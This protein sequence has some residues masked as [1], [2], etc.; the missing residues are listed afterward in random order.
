LEELKSTREFND[1]A[2]KV[3]TP[4]YD[5]LLAE[6]PKGY[7]ETELPQFR[8]YVFPTRVAEMLND[9]H[10]KAAVDGVAV[11]YGKINQVMRNAIFFNPLIHIP[12]IGNH[13]LVDRGVTPWQ[14][15][16]DYSTLGATSVKAWKA[17]T[18]MNEDYVAALDAGAHLLFAKTKME[19]MAQ[20]FLEKA[21]VELAADKTL[22][23]HIGAELGVLN[24]VTWVKSV[25]KFSSKATWA[26]NDIATLQRVYERMESGGL[27][28]E[29]A[30]EET[31]KHI[32]NYRIP[33]RVLNSRTI[34]SILKGDSG[35]TMFGAYHYGALK[36]YGEMIGNLVD[37]M[38]GKAA[39]GVVAETLDKIAALAVATYVIYPMLDKAAQTVTGNPNAS[40]RRAGAST[41]LANAQKLIE[42]ATADSEYTKTGKLK[43]GV[44]SVDIARF[45]QSIVTPSVGLKVGMEFYFGR[46]TF[47]GRP[48]SYGQKAM[49]ALS[50]IDYARQMYDGSMGFGQ[51]VA[52]LIGVKLPE[53][54]GGKHRKI[55]LGGYPE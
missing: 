25:Y 21:G 12:N 22:A 33:A 11:A 10:R 31:A 18:T 35:L 34:A 14:K 43:N 54:K 7:R 45:V 26:A 2:V 48:I 36:S 9:F 42:K 23:G 27:S 47:N 28:L 4:E 20:M 44:T 39:P 49:G 15:P 17:V 5:R 29:Q 8:G 46:D 3:N 30:V 24:P 6:D 40:V 55:G 38:R 19:S 32:P 51:F 1:L 37:A 52:G 13:W 50:P 16:G 41:I 53:E